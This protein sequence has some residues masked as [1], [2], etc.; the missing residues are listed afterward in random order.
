MKVQIIGNSVE[1]LATRLRRHLDLDV[2]AGL[3]TGRDPY[4][5]V[6]CDTGRL[7]EILSDDRLAVL[8]LVEPGI[9]A[10][11]AATRMLAAHSR[12]ALE[13]VEHVA[14]RIHASRT[15]TLMQSLALG[16][17]RYARSLENATAQEANLVQSAPAGGSWMTTERVIGLV[18]LRLGLIGFG[19]MARL[20]A[21][22][23]A[24]AGLEIEYW[25]QTPEQRTI[26]EHDGV[27][28]RVKARESSFSEVLRNADVIAFDLEYGADSIR[29]IDAPEFALMRRGVMLVNTTHGRVIDEGALIQ[30]LRM[31]S[32]AAVALDRFN[33]EPL[34]ADSPLRD[35]EN[36]L[37]TPGTAIPDAETV[38]EETARLIAV[39][40]DGYLPGRPLR[41]VR[42]QVRRPP[43]N[44]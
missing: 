4:A 5:A 10:R 3:A 20:L 43:E 42:R 18:G 30:T 37:L 35:F 38:L 41:K 44:R 21:V 16:V 25:P 13:I 6:L 17:H 26:V 24:K 12:P 40:L 34:P 33:Y 2:G 19:T 28:L 22:H 1:Q 11:D 9:E 36:V 29:I 32:L 8:V 31:G 7:E 14:A 27:A 15:W 23:A 39:A